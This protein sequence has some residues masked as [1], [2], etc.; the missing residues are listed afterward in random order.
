MHQC[1]LGAVLYRVKSDRTQSSW[2][3]GVDYGEA[4]G[5]KIQLGEYVGLGLLEQADKLGWAPAH[6]SDT[7]VRPAAAGKAKSS[8]IL[9]GIRHLHNGI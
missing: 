8:L 4:L 7:V 6:L 5:G 9:Q 1:T 3:G 2:I